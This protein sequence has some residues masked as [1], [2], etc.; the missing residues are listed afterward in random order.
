MET[1]IQPLAK[2]STSIQLNTRGCGRSASV[3]V[4]AESTRPER[5]RGPLRKLC[6]NGC[7][8][9]LSWKAMMRTPPFCAQIVAVWCMLS[10]TLCTAETSSFERTS[11]ANQ[12]SGMLSG[13]LAAE[14][15]SETHDYHSR[16]QKVSSVISVKRRAGTFCNTEGT[17]FSAP[18]AAVRCERFGLTEMPTFT[19]L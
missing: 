3:P 8:I 13:R 7:K 19:S 6:E 17:S 11:A 4:S 5:T 10:R 16:Q 15:T 18:Y 9:V 12:L 14:A 1:R 2:N